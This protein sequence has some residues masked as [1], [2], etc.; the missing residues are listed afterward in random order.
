MGGNRPGGGDG[1]RGNERFTIYPQNIVWYDLR[2]PWCQKVSDV[3]V[4]VGCWQEVVFV[5][6]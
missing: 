4:G 3:V 1:G 6:C 5:G 2:N